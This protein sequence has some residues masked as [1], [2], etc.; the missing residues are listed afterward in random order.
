MTMMKLSSLAVGIAAFAVAC[1]DP[2][3][4]PSRTLAVGPSMLHLPPETYNFPPGFPEGLQP[5][6]VRACKTANEGG[7]FRFTATTDGTGTLIADADAV[8]A[9]NQFD[10][11][12]GAG[13]GTTCVLVYDSQSGIPLSTIETVTI[14]EGPD[15]TADWDLTAIHIRQ[16][17]AASPTYTA[18]HLADVE[19]LGNR[20]ATLKINDDMGRIVTFTNDFTQAPPPEIC[21]FIT[22]GRLV[23]E[24]GGTRVV[25]SGNAGGNA[26]GGGI[27]GEFHIYVNG[28]DYH[29]A[30]IDTYGPI[31]AGPLSG[32]TNSRVV[33]GIAKNGSAVEL[34]LYDGGEPGKDTD[35]VW[36]AIDANTVIGGGN[37]QTIDQG[38]MQ[39]HPTCRGPDDV[40]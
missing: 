30:D 17:L 13:G 29:V 18:A 4:G 6:N 26:P 10:I 8:A 5:G 37:G 28:V 11:T 31:A 35:R 24:E 22:F 40:N 12:V 3:T 2:A 9:G 33:T 34:R 36:V 16:L 38:N 15:L 21:D 7:T 14:V 1:A 19:D 39:Y 20:T 25:I 27:L 23:W 32:L